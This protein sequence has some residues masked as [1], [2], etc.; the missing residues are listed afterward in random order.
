[1]AT[2]A[3]LLEVEALGCRRGGVW[4]FAGVQFAVAAGDLLEISGPN[5]VG[6]SSLLR[7]LAGIAPPSQG[8]VRAHVRTAY[9]GH[10]PALKPRRSV[11][12]E[13]DYW[14]GL[15]ASGRAVTDA[16]QRFG[17]DDL[18]FLECRLLSNGQRRRVALARCWLADARLWL[19]DEPL[20]GLDTAGRD[21]LMAAVM[22]HLAA[23]GAAVVV[24]HQPLDA[25]HRRLVLAA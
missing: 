9:S 5:G 14:A 20:V 1:M 15:Y 19:L 16:L 22:A 21:A 18:A 25:P 11:H 17:L 12:A 24:S 3:S 10:E 13:L 6:K 23:G 4:L 8:Q 2:D 7:I